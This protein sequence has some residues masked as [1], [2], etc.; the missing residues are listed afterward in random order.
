MVAAS[1]VWNRKRALAFAAA[2]V[3]VCAAGIV[4][5]N[6]STEGW[7]L[8]FITL[9]SE[10]GISKPPYWPG[11]YLPLLPLTLV[12][13]A[14]F[15]LKFRKSPAQGAAYALVGA[16]LIGSTVVSLLHFGSYINVLFPACAFL[17]L[18]AGLAI[19]SRWTSKN[20]FLGI[21]ALVAVQF[22][23]LAY[24]Y[25]GLVPAAEDRAIG[26]KTIALIAGIQGD[27]FV[28]VHN[29]L[30][31]L[32]G[33]R[34]NANL[35]ILDDILRGKDKQLA[36]ESLEEF[37]NALLRKEFSTVILDNHPQWMYAKIMGALNASYVLRERLFL[38]ETGYVTLGAFRT[39]PEELYVPRD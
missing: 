38:N 8:Y 39:R 2:F 27:V 10:H 23:T 22:G 4:L 16:G 5:L 32:L 34:P 3:V 26:D 36:A 14:F 13:V 12:T 7:F 28:P 9:P 33:R 24:A 37:R 21:L 31:A 30:P 15:A 11:H 6:H 17:A 18:A 19:G 29:H 35:L 1:A 25:D 20:V